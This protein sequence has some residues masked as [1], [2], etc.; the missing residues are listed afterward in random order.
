VTLAAATPLIT[1]ARRSCQKRQREKENAEVK[2]QKKSGV[3]LFTQVQ[4]FREVHVR[5]LFQ[6]Q[7]LNI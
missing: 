3:A 4:E 5:P 1:H 6:E 2:R 7:P